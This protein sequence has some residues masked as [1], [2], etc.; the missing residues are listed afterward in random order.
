MDIK[1]IKEGSRWIGKNN[2][3]E[4]EIPVSQTAPTPTVSAVQP[5]A[6]E[7]VMPSIAPEDMPDPDAPVAS[8]PVVGETVIPEP[9]T[10]A[11]S[12]MSMFTENL[13]PDIED[14]ERLISQL[15]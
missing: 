9:A 8:G 3:G 11:D 7:I 2:E 15:E 5:K 13:L 10:A 14:S 12:D 6:E 1:D 4:I